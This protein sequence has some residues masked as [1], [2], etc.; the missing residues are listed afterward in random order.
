MKIGSKTV[1]DITPEKLS[2]ILKNPMRILILCMVHIKLD[3]NDVGVKGAE[4]I[5]KMLKNNDSLNL[6]DL[7]NI[8]KVYI[9]NNK[10]F[11]E[12]VNY[13]AEALKT[14]NTLTLLNL[15]NIWFNN[16]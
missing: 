7:R 15:G 14:N 9:G 5:G 16:Q 10:I 3:C 1:C 12:G 6:L 8:I 4:I 13:I 2:T 11:D